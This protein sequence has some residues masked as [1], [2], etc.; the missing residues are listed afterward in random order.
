M[1]TETKPAL[2]CVIE[3]LAPAFRLRPPLPWPFPLGLASFASLSSSLGR[4]GLAGLVLPARFFVLRLS[5]G[6]FQVL[7]LRRS[8]GGFQVLALRLC[9]GFQVITADPKQ[10]LL[11][12]VG[13][14]A[15]VHDGCFER[16]R[17]HELVPRHKNM[18]YLFVGHAPNQS[19]TAA[20]LPNA[21]T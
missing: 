1:T 21:S 3:L 16:I 11:V 7:A 12:R 5:I 9:C 19:A 4:A 20:N 15:A 10:R 14:V 18:L 13:E 6:G 2:S 17:V 8:L